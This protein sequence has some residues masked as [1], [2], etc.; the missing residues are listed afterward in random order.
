MAHVFSWSDTVSA[1]EE[2]LEA[3]RAAVEP[4]VHALGF[5]VYDVELL[6]GAGARTLRLTVTRDAGVDLD[7][8]TAVTQAVSPL[9]DTVDALNGSYLLEVSSPGVE[10]SLRRPEHY[11]GAVGEQ[12]SIKFHTDAGPRRV[13]GILADA[14]ADHVAVQED[15][16]RVDIPLAAVTQARTV[17]EWGPQPRPGKAAKAA[18]SGKAR[19]R[20]K[21]SR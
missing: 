6:G 18:K 15:D 10:R 7:A 5:D 2:Q 9:L 21:E 12:V 20:A 19:A 4:A 1:T 14:G 13:R 3:V 17:F 11:A 16:V 8:I